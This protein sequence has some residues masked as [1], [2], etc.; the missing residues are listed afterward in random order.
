MSKDMVRSIINHQQQP[1]T[2]KASNGTNSQRP[3][4]T[5]ATTNNSQRAAV[6]L[7]YQQLGCTTPETDQMVFNGAGPRS[8]WT[9]WS[10]ESSL[11]PF[12]KTNLIRPDSF[13][14]A[15]SISVVILCAHVFGICFHKGGKTS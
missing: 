1:P 15:T 14:K 7:L 4:I 6:H 13:D 2:A 12:H 10:S 8:T 5:T 9:S 11:F 3:T